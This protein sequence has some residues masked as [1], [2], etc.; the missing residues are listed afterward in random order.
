MTVLHLVRHAAHDLLG[1][2]LVGRAPGVSLNGTG[3]RQADALA[4]R[5]AALPIQSVLSSPRERARETAAP[6]ARG[7]GLDVLVAPELDE[8]DCGSWTGWSFAALDPDP[9]WRQY[10]RL[11]STTQTPDGE[12]MLEV[13]ARAVRLAERLRLVSPR[14][15]L[16]L[17]SHGDVIRAMLLHYLCMPIDAVHRLE[18]A[19]A[20]ITT[21]R[22]GDREPLLLRL[23]EPAEVTPEPH[24]TALPGGPFCEMPSG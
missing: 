11:R 9:Q 18:V 5:F 3:R 2:I 17:V 19:P 16:V 21:L 15:Q 12:F 6:I 8:V 14:H 23:N 20:S 22:L 7:H 4:A 24:G 13:Q 1:R 10:N